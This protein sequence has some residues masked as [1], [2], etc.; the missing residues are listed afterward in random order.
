[1]KDSSE[2]HSQHSRSIEKNKFEGCPYLE[3][4]EVGTLLL[5]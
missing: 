4:D 5:V 3:V 2:L 1:M